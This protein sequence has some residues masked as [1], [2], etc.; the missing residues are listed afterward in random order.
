MRLV[1]AV[2][3]TSR[4]QN[5]TAAKAAGRPRLPRLLHFV[6]RFLQPCG[7]FSRSGS[8]RA[9]VAFQRLFMALALEDP[10]E[11]CLAECRASFQS[12]RHENNYRDP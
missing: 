12:V 10:L 9:A 6:S 4:A 3:Q 8:N 7:S 2:T 5:D 11:W 1:A